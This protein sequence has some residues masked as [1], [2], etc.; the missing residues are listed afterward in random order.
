MS[1]L[2]RAI[3]LSFWKALVFLRGIC[4][5]GAVRNQTIDW[6]L[7]YQVFSTRYKII[8]LI[9]MGIIPMEFRVDFCRRKK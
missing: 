7:K 6:E 2:S 4:L 8:G 1:I 9:F 5:P 3:F